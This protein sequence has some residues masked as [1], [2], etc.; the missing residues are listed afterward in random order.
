[1]TDNELKMHI[2]LQPFYLKFKGEWQTG[3]KVVDPENDVYFVDTSVFSIFP[4][5]KDSYDDCIW[6]P[7]TIDTENPERGLWGMLKGIKE[8]YVFG[9]RCELTVDR[10]LIISKCTTP[11]EA[12]LKTL[13][14]QEG[15]ENGAS[16]S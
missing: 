7:R 13:C 12:I 8:L 15:V 4:S 2:A 14:E 1:M 6:I 9:D 11:T 16:R 5:L 10:G 3:D